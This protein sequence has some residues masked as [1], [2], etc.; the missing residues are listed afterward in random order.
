M[1][2]GIAAR[3]TQIIGTGGLVLPS[4]DF[5]GSS[6][7]RQERMEAWLTRLE[8]WRGPRRMQAASLSIWRA[9]S[10]GLHSL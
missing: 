6:D 7:S 2:A 5:L 3:P 9:S 8:V 10:T 4:Q 1:D